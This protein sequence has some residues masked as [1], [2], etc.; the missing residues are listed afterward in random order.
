MNEALIDPQF[1]SLGGLDNLFGVVG[2]PSKR[3]SGDVLFGSTKEVWRGT[4]AAVDGMLLKCIDA[5]GEDEFAQ[6]RR[7]VFPQY[8]RIVQALA[9]LVR[10]LATDQ[11]VDNLVRESFCE[12]E[13]DFRE[14]GPE[15]FGSTAADQAIFTVWTLRRTSRLLSDLVGTRPA[16]QDLLERDCKMASD[17][18]TYALWAQFHLDCLVGAIRF[19]KPIQLAVLPSIEDGLRAAVDAYGLAREGVRLREQ[20][21]IAPEPVV[22][23]DEEDQEL[24]D[25]SMRDLEHEAL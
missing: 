11:M 19:D 25:S 13:H 8:A 17:F 23:W 20:V 10:V 22:E 6:R 21:P 3:S 4:K 1:V 7:V 16:R 12:L 9:S 2:L 15:R 24:L 14:Q 18:V 5:K